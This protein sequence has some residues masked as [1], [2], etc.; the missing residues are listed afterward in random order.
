MQLAEGGVLFAAI[1]WLCAAIMWAMALWAF[2]RSTPMHFWAGSTVKPEEIADIPAYNRENGIMW[3]I[4]G[5]GL[6]VSGVVGLFYII[7]GTILMVIVCGPGI[8][9]LFWNYKRIYNK[10]KTA[11][12]KYSW[13]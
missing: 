12:T 8:G 1:S 13:F 2:R 3:L 9:F 10:Y 5:A 4:Y 6:F 11:N 7:A